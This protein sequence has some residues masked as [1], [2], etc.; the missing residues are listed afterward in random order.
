MT[1]SVRRSNVPLR[2]TPSSSP[3]PLYEGFPTLHSTPPCCIYM[4]FV[5]P[6]GRR[7]MGMFPARIPRSRVS[8]RCIF[9]GRLSL[10]K[11]G[12]DVSFL[13]YL[14][15]SLLR[16]SELSTVCRLMVSRRLPHSRCRSQQ[17]A[18]LVSRMYSTA[19]STEGL[20]VG[21]RPVAS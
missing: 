16:P 19:S 15:F 8:P 21:R 4:D 12:T 17:A 14:P 5:P 20:D 1:K 11:T 7:S 2:A 18:R 6:T 3:A 10:S 9:I 13:L